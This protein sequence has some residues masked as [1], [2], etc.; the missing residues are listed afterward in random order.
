MQRL[1]LSIRRSV[2]IMIAVGG[3]MT[4][5]PAVSQ[6]ALVFYI[7]RGLFNA[8]EP[9]LPVQSFDSA[10]LFNQPYVFETNGL[11]SATSNAVFAAGSILPGLTLSTLNPGAQSTALIVY[12]GGPVG[13]KSVGNNWYGDTLVLSFAP[14]AF[15]VAADIFANTSGG[16]SYAGNITAEMF[17]GT[18]PLGS[19]PLTETAGGSVFLGV[20]STTLPITSVEITWGGDNDA[21]TYVSS[22]A[23]GSSL[24]NLSIVANGANSVKLFWPGPAGAFT[25]QQNS[26]LATTNWTTAGYAITNSAGTNSCTVTPAMGNRFFRLTYP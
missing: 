18:T 15:A 10:N 3:L 1:I 17:N 11:N 19:K 13:T 20:S 6:G 24:P 25:L 2:A 7:T 12:G 14:G 16:P 4:T 23:F 8:A 22:I 21:T 5:A 26:D 9:G